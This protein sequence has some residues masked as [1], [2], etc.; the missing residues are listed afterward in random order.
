MDCLVGIVGVDGKEAWSEKSF[1][2]RT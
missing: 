2:P 1:E